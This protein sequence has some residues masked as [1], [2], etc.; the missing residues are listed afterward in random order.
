MQAPK[1]RMA[2]VF[3]AAFG[4]SVLRESKPSTLLDLGCGRFGVQGQE[5]GSGV[6]EMLTISLRPLNEFGSR[7]LPA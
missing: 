6:K 1:C 7:N 2:A 4:G 3:G 5:C